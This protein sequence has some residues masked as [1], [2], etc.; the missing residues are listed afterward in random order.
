MPD[1]TSKLMLLISTSPLGVTKGTDSNLK[2]GGMGGGKRRGEKGRGKEKKGEGG[3][4][5]KGGKV[6]KSEKPYLSL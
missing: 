4:R 1:F 3:R 6:K 5:K 2:E